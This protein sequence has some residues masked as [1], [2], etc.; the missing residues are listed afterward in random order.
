MAPTG[1]PDWW[2][3]SYSTCIVLV[4]CNWDDWENSSTLTSQWVIVEENHKFEEETIHRNEMS[5]FFWC[6]KAL[7]IYV[8][9]VP[10]VF[11]LMFSFKMK[12]S[13][14]KRAKGVSVTNITKEECVTLKSM[15]YFESVL[16]CTISFKT[17]LFMAFINKTPPYMSVLLLLRSTGIH[18]SWKMGRICECAMNILFVSLFEWFEESE[19]HFVHTTS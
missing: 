13:W 2:R 5:N 3:S 10:N 19:Q 18:W 6:D 9:L 8:T 12:I 11:G 7:Y 16:F 17:V 1:H 4:W 15:A 14:T